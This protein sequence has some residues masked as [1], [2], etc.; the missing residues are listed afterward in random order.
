MFLGVLLTNLKDFFF[1]N[2]V[3]EISQYSKYVVYI[4][5]EKCSEVPLDRLNRFYSIR[6]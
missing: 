4:F 5:F 1:G 3:E 6:T 2:S